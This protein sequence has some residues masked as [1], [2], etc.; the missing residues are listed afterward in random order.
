MHALI[1]QSLANAVVVL[2]LEASDKVNV[3]R[4]LVNK[5]QGDKRI[6]DLDLLEK[7][8][9]EREEEMSTGTEK[10]LALH[11]AR[12]LAVDEMAVVF[13]RLKDPVDFGSLDEN[14]SDL[15][16]FTA[17]P[18]KSVQQYLKLTAH[19]IRVA[20]KGETQAELRAAKSSEEVLKALGVL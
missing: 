4:E 18:R 11:H 16:F 12:S 20:S 1:K 19:I 3:I 14:M 6:R 2:D 8:A 15:I 9:L 10:S 5:L 7:D 13:A 17:A